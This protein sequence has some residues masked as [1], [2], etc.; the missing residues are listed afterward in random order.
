MATKHAANT[1]YLGV[2]AYATQIRFDPL[3]AAPEYWDENYSLIESETRNTQFWKLNLDSG[4]NALITR[5]EWE[6]IGPRVRFSLAS[7][8]AT[9]APHLRPLGRILTLPAYLKDAHPPISFIFNGPHEEVPS[10]IQSSLSSD[11]CSPTETVAFVG[12]LRRPYSDGDD[13]CVEFMVKQNNSWRSL[14]VAQLAGTAGLARKDPDFGNQRGFIARGTHYGS[15]FQDKLWIVPV[16]PNPY[17]PP[18][19]DAPLADSPA[20]APEPV[21][22][23]KP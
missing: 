1:L 22:V 8:T 17:L 21:I 7:A 3:S 20:A 15:L 5:A 2:L 4:D 10:R 19:P 11:L 16:P 18:K 12:T 9:I 13:L 23:P 14:G 6:A